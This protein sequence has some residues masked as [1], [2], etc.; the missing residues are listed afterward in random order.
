MAEELLKNI[1]FE[2]FALALKELLDFGY[3]ELTYRVV[4]RDKKID[5]VNVSKTT[6]YKPE[7]G[8]I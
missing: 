3:G 1:E 2:K 6:T 5:L 8:K 7:G 4:V